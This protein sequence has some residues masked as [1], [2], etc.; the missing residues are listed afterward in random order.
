MAKQSIDNGIKNSSLTLVS[1][2]RS[3]GYF[4]LC[5][6]FNHNNEKS[7]KLSKHCLQIALKQLNDGEFPSRE[8]DI[9]S[10]LEIIKLIIESSNNHT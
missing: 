5:D 9:N 3:A 4:F 7:I 2:S 10:I 1:S 6:F 8:K